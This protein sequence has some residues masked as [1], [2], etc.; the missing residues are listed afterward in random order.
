MTWLA[1]LPL[2]RRERIEGEGPCRARIFWRA[3]QDSAPGFSDIIFPFPAGPEKRR[4]ALEPALSATEGFLLRSPFFIVILEPPQRRI[5]DLSSPRP[6]RARIE[7]PALS[8]P[9]GEGPYPAHIFRARLKILLLLRKRA[10]VM[11][12]SPARER[13]KAEGQIT[14]RDSARFRIPLLLTRTSGNSR[15]RDV[16]CGRH[17][18]TLVDEE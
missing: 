4:Q 9:K 11:Q 13:I 6:V 16:I 1:I 7:E 8:L 17:S 5:P 10:K 18:L 14:A 12:T 2:S 15:L 3:I